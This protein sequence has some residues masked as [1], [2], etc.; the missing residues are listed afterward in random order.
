MCVHVEHM[1]ITQ[2]WFL[3]IA[4]HYAERIGL[5]ERIDQLLDCQMEVSP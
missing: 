1:Q 4:S 5:V 3:P 2:V